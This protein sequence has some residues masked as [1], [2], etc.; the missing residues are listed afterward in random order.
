MPNK[1]KYDACRWNKVI[2]KGHNIRRQQQRIQKQN[3]NDI[4]EYLQKERNRKQNLKTMMFSDTMHSLSQPYQKSISESLFELLPNEHVTKLLTD[5]NKS[6]KYNEDAT[7]LTCP[8]DIFWIIE[9][10][11]NLQSIIALRKTCKRFKSQLYEIGYHNISIYD[12]KY[13]NHRKN[14]TMYSYGDVTE[15]KMCDYE[16]IKNDIKYFS[17]L[18]S[19]IGELQLTIRFDDYLN[20]S[21]VILSDDFNYVKSIYYS[22]VGTHNE[23]IRLC[24]C[25]SYSLIS[26][27]IDTNCKLNKVDLIV[28]DSLDEN[29]LHDFV[30]SFSNCY[31]L[32]FIRI[33]FKNYREIKLIKSDIFMPRVETIEF[34]NE[35][36]Q[37][38][39]LGFYRQIRSGSKMGN[40]NS[41]QSAH[42]VC[43]NLKTIRFVKMCITLKVINLLISSDCRLKRIEFVKCNFNEEKNQIIALLSTLM[44]EEIMIDRKLV[45]DVLLS[46]LK[47]LR[48]VTIISPLH[49]LELYMNPPT[50]LNFNSVSLTELHINDES[51]TDAITDAIINNLAT[52]CP[53]LKSLSISTRSS[54]NSINGLANH[55]TLQKIVIDGTKMDHVII[56]DIKILASCPNL[57]DLIM[58]NVILP[59]M[60]EF[61]DFHN[62]KLQSICLK[63]C[64]IF[65]F[66][67]LTD[68]SENEFLRLLY[69]DTYL[70]AINDWSIRMGLALAKCPHLISV[71]V[72][73]CT[74]TDH[75]FFELKKSRT[76]RYVYMRD[77]MGNYEAMSNI[78][79][80]IINKIAEIIWYIFTGISENYCD[81][82]MIKFLIRTNQNFF[83]K[84]D[85]ITIMRDLTE[86]YGHA[87][88]S[89]INYLHM[90]NKCKQHAQQLL[91]KC[92]VTYM[93]IVELKKCLTIKSIDIMNS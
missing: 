48:C 33:K 18:V 54:I 84:I 12:K 13:C 46:N 40:I 50:Q 61:D 4:K 58:I 90:L 75:F 3:K 82:N 74:F 23:I 52:R 24:T 29:L 22:I 7:L 71:N 87:I 2:P 69:K 15:H 85:P 80:N 41:P 77:C 17:T 43:P 26:N 78:E 56:H 93:A 65:P 47:N 38:S 6:T 66:K 14:F 92:T 45:V 79:D 44:I 91:S 10:Y 36:E 42:F 88:S 67:D 60:M 8:N 76:L 31:K 73:K 5:A 21:N 81:L 72:V 20:I 49:F 64:K 19:K 53:N 89:G 32:K 57:T 55:M 30:S 37:Y 25:C 1:A 16:L 51:A 70:F 59:T 63:N 39:G 83:N 68:L 11:M 28:D 9:K 27:Q 35:Y 62:T 34:V 86:F